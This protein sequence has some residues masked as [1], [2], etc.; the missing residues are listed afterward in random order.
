MWFKIFPSNMENIVYT[1]FEDKIVTAS[2]SCVKNERDSVRR[3][4]W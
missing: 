1:L 2:I 3:R 4:E